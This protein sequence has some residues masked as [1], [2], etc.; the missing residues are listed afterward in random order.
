MRR[1]VVLAKDEVRLEHLSDAVRE[2]RSVAGTPLRAAGEIPGGDIKSAVADLERRSIEVALAQAEGN[3]SR[4]AESLGI[5]RFALQR[6]LEKYGMGK[7]ARR[8][9]GEETGS[10]TADNG[11]RGP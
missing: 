7:K 5:S 9:A 1:L 11:G 8:G 2:G 4:A 10:G 3:K 6:K